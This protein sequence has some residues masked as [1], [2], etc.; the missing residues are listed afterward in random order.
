[1]QMPSL[2]GEKTVPMTTSITHWRSS[3]LVFIFLLCSACGNSTGPEQASGVASGEG[4]AAIPDKTPVTPPVGAGANL[5]PCTS[6]VA[7]AQTAIASLLP[8]VSTVEARNRA[9]DQFGG[10]FRVGGNAAELGYIDY[11]TQRLKAIGATQVVK[12]PY[13]FTAWSAKSSSLLEVSGPA[14][15]PIRVSYYI[16]AS[17]STGPAGIQAPLV[18]LPAISALNF[19]PAI[20]QAIIEQNPGSLMAAV[21]G[22]VD[23]DIS[24]GI[25]LAQVITAGDVSGKIVMYDVPK[26]PLTLAPFFAAASY[27]NNA[28]GTMSPTTLYLRPYV[29]MLALPYIDKALFQAG[30]V[31]IIAVIDYPPTE[32]DL[33]YYPFGAVSETPG[34]PGLYLDRN[35]GNALKKQ[36]TVAGTAPLVMKLTLD[37]TQATATSYNVVAVVPG[38]CASEIL[39]SSHSDGPNSIEDDGPAAILSIAEYF[40]KAPVEQRRRT[41]RIMISGGHFEGAFGQGSGGL[42]PA[43]FGSPGMTSYISQ[44]QAD[45]TAN[46]LTAIELEHLGARE[47]LE[48][49]PGTM[50]LDGLPEIGAIWT[51]PQSVQATEATTW[52]QNFDRTFVTSPLPFGE[53]GPWSAQAGLPLIQYI[54]GPDYLLNGPLPAVSDLYT[55][56]DLEQ[57][58]IS[59]FIQMILNLNTQTA[60]SLRMGANHLP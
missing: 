7:S 29:D 49:S 8:S 16:P 45:L 51:T 34:T 26:V 57:R 31:G 10:G 27:V 3:A 11:L 24:G 35:T 13:T 47:W 55:D 12:E 4:M 23:G 22:V 33:S 37:A 19:A 53:G 5:G 58:Q 41:L 14:P 39:I 28:S 1:M 52:A 59:S 9:V 38:Q 30:A 43:T 20:S 50:A 6:D 15:G 21:Q 2:S 32:S 46:T 18:Y 48:L 42:S 40:A 56:Y 60:D 17:G 36:L 54:P 44:H 25:S